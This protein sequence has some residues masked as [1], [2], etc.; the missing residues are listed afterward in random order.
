MYL[1]IGVEPTK[2][3]AC[4]VVVLEQAVDRDLVALQ[5][6]ETAGRE[7]GLGEELGDEQV[8]RRVLLAR[9]E[10]ERV[11]AG[12][13]VGEHPHRDHRREVER[14]DPGDDAERLA[15]RVHVDP[16][17]GLLGVVTLDQLRDPARVL[18]VLEAAGDLAHRV[19]E[20][21][22]VLGRQH[23]GQLLAVGVD[24]LAHPEHHLGAL[25]ERRRTPG[26][27]GRCRR[28]DRGV[29]LCDRRESDLAGLLAGRRVV[30]GRRVARR[31]LDDP[32]VD[33]MADPIHR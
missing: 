28:R 10:H 12:E 3:T 14:R 24:Q 20:H 23:R 4:D 16:A 21:L 26:R 27:E 6:V 19:G 5:H 15:D 9:L 1:A 29:D 8:D 32:S 7:A 11:A 17:G 13:G 30:D 33:P 18:D 25:G 2:L 22:A 31:R